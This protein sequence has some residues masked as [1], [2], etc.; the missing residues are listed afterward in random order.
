MKKNP[1]KIGKQGKI[2]IGKKEIKKNF[3]AALAPFNGIGLL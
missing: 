3:Q 1:V 2:V